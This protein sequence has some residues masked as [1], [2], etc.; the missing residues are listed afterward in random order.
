MVIHQKTLRS[1]MIEV[2]IN[3][4]S[5]MFLSEGSAKGYSDKELKSHLLKEFKKYVVHKQILFEFGDG[6]FYRRKK[7]V[8]SLDKCLIYVDVLP[9]YSTIGICKTI[10]RLKE[11]LEHILPSPGNASYEP[12]KEKLQTLIKITNRYINSRT[13]GKYNDPR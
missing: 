1:G 3:G 5:K 11:S 4:I 13:Q 8:A 12:Q 6:S 10:I 2:T 7:K 9:Q